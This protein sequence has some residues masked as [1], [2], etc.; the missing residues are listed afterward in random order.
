MDSMKDAACRGY[1]QP[2]FNGASSARFY[3]KTFEITGLYRKAASALGRGVS[4]FVGL[5]CIASLIFV[6]LTHALPGSV[7][8]MS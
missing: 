1:P 2:K 4:F 8:S 3:N 6:L 7:S 5:F